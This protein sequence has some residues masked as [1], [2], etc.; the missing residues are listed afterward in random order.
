MKKAAV[1]G[2]LGLSIPLIGQ[3]VLLNQWWSSRNSPGWLSVGDEL[4]EVLSSEDNR[5]AGDLADGKPIVLL[6]FSAQCAH[7]IE[8]APHWRAWLEENGRSWNVKAVTRDSTSE[9][10]RFLRQHGLPADVLPG[11]R[12]GSLRQSLT[13]RTPWVYITDREGRVLTEGHGARLPE[14]SR[15]ALTSMQGGSCP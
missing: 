7:C 15:T 13:S 3:V 11:Q 4:A 8:I 14:L 2:V 12:L 1:I 6:V 9:G 10:E 5:A